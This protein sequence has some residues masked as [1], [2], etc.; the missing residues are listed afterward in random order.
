VTNLGKAQLPLTIVIFLEGLV[1]GLH[2]LH[3]ISTTWTV[4]AFFAVIIPFATLKAFVDFRN[5]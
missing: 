2:A 1:L 3:I 5:H 4:I